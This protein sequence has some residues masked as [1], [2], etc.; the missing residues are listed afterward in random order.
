MTEPGDSGVPEQIGAAEESA[1][2]AILLG[3]LLA[4]AGLLLA[5]GLLGL[6]LLTAALLRSWDV[7]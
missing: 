1:M 4:A 7:W 6:A 5:A 3:G 2:A